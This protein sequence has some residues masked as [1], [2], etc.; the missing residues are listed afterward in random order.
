VLSKRDKAVLLKFAKKYKLTSVFLF[1][2]SIDKENPND[3]DI[4]IRGIKPELFFTFYG[5]LMLQVPK[6]LDIIN[7]D[8]E[9]SFS[10]LIEKEGIKL[11]G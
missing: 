8:K 7:L 6:R 4:G 3:I 10:R 2:S 1:G 9:N 11:Y 5:E